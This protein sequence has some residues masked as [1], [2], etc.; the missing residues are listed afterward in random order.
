MPFLIKI[1]II[2]LCSLPTLKIVNLN[3]M[4]IL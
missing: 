2:F 4:K 1:K 3:N